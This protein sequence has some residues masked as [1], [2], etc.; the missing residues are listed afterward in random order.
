MSE[1]PI[2]DNGE[3]SV[4]ALDRRGGALVIATSSGYVTHLPPA[5]VEAIARA[6]D[7]RQLET[8]GPEWQSAVEGFAPR[9]PAPNDITV[10][11]HLGGNEI[12]RHVIDT[13]NRS[14]R[15][16]A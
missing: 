8:A 13:I 4:E 6:H 3:V 1:R 7:E 11:I 12:G 10:T 2:Y 5:A 15:R 16:H 14:V 9:N